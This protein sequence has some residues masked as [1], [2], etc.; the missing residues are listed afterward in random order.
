[1]IFNN[2]LKKILL[3]FLSDIN[4]RTSECRNN[5]FCN[6][7]HPSICKGAFD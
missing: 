1:M 2:V 3:I 5:S 4:S 7:G 6:S